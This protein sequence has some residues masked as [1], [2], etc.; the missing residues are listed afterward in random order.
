MLIVRFHLD[1]SDL[2][3][4]IFKQKVISG[5]AAHQAAASHYHIKFRL[6]IP[7]PIASQSRL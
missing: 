1:N 3:G 2:Q 6:H 7:F 5:R 4:W